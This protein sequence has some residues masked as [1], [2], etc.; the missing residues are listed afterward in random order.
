[1]AVRLSALRTDRALLLRNIIFLLMV[2][3]SIRGWVIPR[4]MVQLEGL[5]KLQK[6]NDL[7]GT[8][9]RKFPAFRIASQSTI[10]GVTACPFDRRIEE[11]SS[12]FI[13]TDIKV[14][15][16]ILCRE[17]N[18]FRDVTSSNLIDSYH[19]LRGTCFPWHD[20]THGESN[21][22]ERF[23]AAVTLW[24]RYVRSSWFESWLGY[25]DNATCSQV[26]SAPTSKTGE[27]ISSYSLSI[28]SRSY[29]IHL[30]HRILPSIAAKY[31]NVL[32]HDMTKQFKLLLPSSGIQCRVV[33]MWTD[34]SEKRIT[35][36]FRVENQPSNIPA[37]IGWLQKCWS[38]QSECW[39]D[40]NL[41]YDAV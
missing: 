5:G 32:R 27:N 37:R 10:N 39:C 34:V 23:S 1:M 25:R 4:A 18:V 11:N 17:I 28:P 31:Q 15:Y 8:R 24:I 33:S 2:L 20:G 30:L 3:I 19:R 26:F 38:F 22:T 6:F 12:K 9:T 36:I 40:G 7:I 13:A 21:T 14:S 29:P 35:S 41:G 16:Y